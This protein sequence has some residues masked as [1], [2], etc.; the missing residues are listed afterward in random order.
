MVFFLNIPSLYNSQLTMSPLQLKDK[1]TRIIMFM[2]LES[3]LTSRPEQGRGTPAE[4]NS[5][6]PD[7]SIQD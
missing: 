3:I 1:L 4:T 5:E 2:I 6:S 7:L